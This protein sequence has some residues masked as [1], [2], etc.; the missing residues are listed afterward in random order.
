LHSFEIKVASLCFLPVVAAGGKFSG[1]FLSGLLLHSMPVELSIEDF[2][3]RRQDLCLLDVR[4]PAEYEQGHIPG[5]V[6]FP[7]FSNEERAEVGTL[8]KQQSP[9]A[10]LKRGLELVGPKLAGFV[11]KAGRLAADKPLALHCWRGGKRSSSMA[12]LLEMAGMEVFVIRGGYK[13]YRQKVMT[14]LEKPVWPFV[15][16]SG[17]TG[18][19]KTLILQELKALG[20]QVVDLE[21]LA[22][23]RGSAF[24]ALGMPP[25]PTTEQFANLLYEELSKM[26][27]SRPVWLENESR[28]IG[29]VFLPDGFWRAMLSS[30]KCSIE[31]P[32]EWRIRQLLRD[33]AGFSKEELQAAF[34]KIAKR[35]GGLRLKEAL[36]AIEE[37]DLELAARLALAYYDK[38]YGKGKKPA[39]VQEGPNLHFAFSR[40]SLSDIART[41]LKVEDRFLREA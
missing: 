30:L 39:E 24:G 34:L 25:Q 19:G 5:A 11:E 18:S 28:S 41:L 29:R 13:A 31:R 27:P 32:L 3:S 37:G 10:A 35:L 4:T 12:W 38:A 1:C 14:A 40:E 22:C 17:K 9:Q 6:N 23:H 15:V 33:Y 21:G 8:Y 7:L 36:Q 20:A 2:L 16:L 26:D